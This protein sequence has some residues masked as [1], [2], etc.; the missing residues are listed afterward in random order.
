MEPINP[1]P[2]NPESINPE[3]INPESINPE[4]INPESNDSESNTSESNDSESNTSETKHE[5]VQAVYKIYLEDQKRK[6]ALR[7]FLNR[8]F[9]SYAKKILRK[10][11][12]KWEELSKIEKEYFAYEYIRKDILLGNHLPDQYAG[13]PLEIELEKYVHDKHFPSKEDLI[14]EIRLRD[15][16]TKTANLKELDRYKKRKQY[17]QFCQCLQAFQPDIHIPDFNEWIKDVVEISSPISDSAIY[18][19]LEEAEKVLTSPITFKTK[20]PN[21]E[22]G[23]STDVLKDAPTVMHHRN[24]YDYLMDANAEYNEHP[25]MQNTSYQIIYEQQLIL[26]ILI[27]ILEKKYYAKIDFKAIKETVKYFY[28][29]PELNE[30]DVL[31]FSTNG[32]P[33]TPEKEEQAKVVAKNLEYIYYRKKRDKLDFFIKDEFGYNEIDDDE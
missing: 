3:P 10:E 30:F 16:L 11:N 19:S 2:I 17:D 29:N 13:S 7:S 5:Y 28:D 20:N 4:S 8:Q 12:A 27:S 33:N 22:K 18:I 25:E 32:E 23:K 1:E 15:N 14:E 24:A 26:E 31:T 9:A 6:D 21:E